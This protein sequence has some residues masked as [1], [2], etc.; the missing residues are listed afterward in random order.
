MMKMI[1]IKNF[2]EYKYYLKVTFRLKSLIFCFNK[3]L[4]YKG[5][6]EVKPRALGGLAGIFLGIINRMLSWLI[7]LEIS[8]YYSNIRWRS[9][10]WILYLYQKG[11]EIWVES[12]RI[13][14]FAYWSQEWRNQWSTERRETFV[15]KEFV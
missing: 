12:R 14:S 6:I 5:G 3:G 7:R 10:M 2:I 11:P 13:N 9:S 4:N 8:A 1:R 15:V